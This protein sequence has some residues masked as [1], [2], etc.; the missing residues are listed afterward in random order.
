MLQVQNIK[1]GTAI[2]TQGDI[3]AVHFYVVKSGSFDVIVDA[4]MCLPLDFLLGLRPA[5]AAE[6]AAGQQFLD[7]S[8]HFVFFILQ[9]LAAVP[10]CSLSFFLGI[11]SSVVRLSPATTGGERT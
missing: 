5:L 7:H 8:I 4:N 11:R 3:N 6:K 10:N 9:V 1:S 2:I